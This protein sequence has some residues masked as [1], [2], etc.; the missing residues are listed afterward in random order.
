MEN[1]T[2]V[3]IMPAT[4]AFESTHMMLTL[5]ITEKAMTAEMLE[6]YHNETDNYEYDFCETSLQIDIHE[7]GSK[8]FMFF[9]E[10]YYNDGTSDS[11]GLYLDLSPEI[12]DY[13]YNMAVK[14]LA[15]N[16]ARYSK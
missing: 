6:D 13:Y 10:K 1:I 16:L 7:D 2:S 9:V 3:K 4:K 12:A 14:Q 5:P 11:S 8:F 15:E